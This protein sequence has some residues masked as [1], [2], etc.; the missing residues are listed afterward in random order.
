MY[1]GK[2]YLYM[3]VNF[4]SITKILNKKYYK[5]ISIAS[6]CT[7]NLRYNVP[8]YL[9]AEMIDISL[10]QR[11]QITSLSTS[12]KGGC[13]LV[14]VMN[15]A[16]MGYVTCYFQRIKLPHFCEATNVVITVRNSDHNLLSHLPLG[17]WGQAAPSPAFS[18]VYT[19][20]LGAVCTHTEY[21]GFDQC[22]T[23][24]DTLVKLLGIR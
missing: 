20:T 11:F 7:A 17:V 3:A 21:A 13:D 24:V 4:T 23:I 12:Y 9:I 8:L 16:D 19:A 6:I 1:R 5:V 15:T 22:Q 14:S 2:F 10:F 18:W